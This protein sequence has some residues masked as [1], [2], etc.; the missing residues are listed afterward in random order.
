MKRG[1]LGK[2]GNFGKQGT[3]LIMGN[4]GTKLL[5]QR[6]RKEVRPGGH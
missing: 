1:E 3:I 6:R 5:F 2:K 4:R